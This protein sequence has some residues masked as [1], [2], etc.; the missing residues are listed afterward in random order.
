MILNIYWNVEPIMFTLKIGSFEMPFSWYGFF[1]AM[2]FLIGQQVVAYL[3]KKD[4]KPK[5]DI[6]SLTIYILIA[7][8]L[9]ARLGHYLF[10][11][12]EFL[13]N[14][15]LQWFL[16]LITPPFAGL[17][18]HGATIAI[19]IGIYLY[20]RK[21]ADQSFL[22]VV[23]RL[24]IGASFAGLIRLGNLFNSEIYGKPTDLPWGFV[25]LRETNPNLLP[26]V[27]RHPTQLYE[28][29]FCMVLFV[30][31]FMMWKYR[32]HLL[33]DGVIAAVF[34]IGLFSFRFIVEFLKNEQVGF[35]QSM[36]LNMGQLLS[37]PAVLFGILIL[38][39]AY[40]KKDKEP[41]HVL[42]TQP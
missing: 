11:E 4:N 42:D 14:S 8:I 33:P 21:K 3:Y 20:S 38:I 13:F 5:T 7:T 26:L 12:W 15:P 28:F 27:P 9:G 29:L 32:R 25:F 23:D 16:T 41:I 19:L 2:A 37:I 22:W 1:F 6:D 30:V 31:T 17:A 34:I 39:Y 10:Y 24:V 36:T 35:E 18:S 40:R